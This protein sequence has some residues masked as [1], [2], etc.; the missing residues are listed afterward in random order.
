MSDRTPQFPRG[1]DRGNVDLRDGRIFSTVSSSYD[2]SGPMLVVLR[3]LIARIE[4]DDQPG[5]IVSI[6][7]ERY[8]V[9]SARDGGPVYSFCVDVEWSIDAGTMSDEL[10]QRLLGL[11]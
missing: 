11:G 5:E 7:I 6:A 1:P 10:R 3:D 4:A 2:H 9:L 8:E